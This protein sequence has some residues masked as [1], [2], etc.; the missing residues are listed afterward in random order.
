MFRQGPA[1]RWV[2]AAWPLLVCALGPPCAREA[3]ALEPSGNSGWVVEE[4]GRKLHYTAGGALERAEL[5]LD[6]NG[7]YEVTERYLEG[8]RT[9]RVTK[10]DGADQ[11]VEVIRWAP[12]GEATLTVRRPDG[13]A[14]VS[15]YRPDG[16]ASLV[17]EDEYGDGV[18]ERT[19]YYDKAGGLERV[20]ES[21][22]SWR[23][24]GGVPVSASV[25]EDGDGV[26]ERVERYGPGGVLCEVSEFDRM[27]R[28]TSVRE[29]DGEG[30]LER[31][32]EDRDGD[33][34]M[35]C[36]VSRVAPGRYR[37]EIDADGDGSPERIE[38]LGGDGSLLAVEEDVDGDGVID[39]RR[40]RAAA[41][42][43]MDE[44]ADKA[45]TGG[46]GDD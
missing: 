18:A 3:F 24:R 13:S 7:T 14:V 11:R 29:L 36:V 6:G 12:G 21:G 26:A 33:G 25:D 27:G 23:Y 42:A 10:I 17:E 8:V 39:V 19:L 41:P 16:S 44:A 35:E 32:S 43:P 28:A 34:R 46:E 5:D 40:R 31:A 38:E 15:T 4:A 30:N 20:E 22:V 37:R 45:R 9:E 1:L 2:L